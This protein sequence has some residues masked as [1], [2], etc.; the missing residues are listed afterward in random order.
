M[1][2]LTKTPRGS[3]SPV[4]PAPL[5]WLRGEIDRLFDDFGQPGR[6]IFN[7]ASRAAG[8]APAMELVDRGKDYQL[9]AEIP[10]LTDKDITVELADGVLTIAGEK[11]E[12]SEHKDGD[13][14]MTERRYGS[15]TRQFTL[16]VDADAETI[17][18]KVKHGVLT[19]RIG[20]DEKA[21]PASRKIEIKG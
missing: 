19:I 1:N 2:E 11:G 14:L 9:T 16:P 20:K 10:G 12:T 7:F 17:D 3:V 8:P 15:F 5:N 13:C 21:P 4:V 6:S 18:A